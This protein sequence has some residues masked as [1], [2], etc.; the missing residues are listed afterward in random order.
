[1]L[2]AEPK[3]HG[4]AVYQT[5]GETNVRWFQDDPRLSLEL[6]GPFA[7]A[8]RGRI[9][10]VGG[11]ASVLVDWLL[12]LPLERIA[13]LD[14]SETALSKAGSRLGD[15]TS[16]VERIAADITEAGFPRHLRCLP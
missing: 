6:I 15:R 9:I 8:D 5:K 14:V 3:E 1:M 7:P 2:R 10:D 4:E 16:R 12:D 11:G 13:V